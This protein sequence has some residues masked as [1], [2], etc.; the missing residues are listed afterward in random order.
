M[1][2]DISA[3]GDVGFNVGWLRAGEYMRYT[4]DVEIDGKGCALCTLHA[5]FEGLAI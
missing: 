2:V 4:V 5:C 3:I 1:D